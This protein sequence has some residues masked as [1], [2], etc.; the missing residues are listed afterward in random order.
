M[1]IDITPIQKSLQLGFVK[2]V[3][4]H[5]FFPDVFLAI[6]MY[7]FSR[8]IIRT[9]LGFGCAMLIGVIILGTFLGIILGTFLRIAPESQ[10]EEPL[11]C[12]EIIHKTI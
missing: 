12:G 10:G 8:R 11:F 7:S 6:L 2:T 9:V 5:F 1:F 3:V 4:N